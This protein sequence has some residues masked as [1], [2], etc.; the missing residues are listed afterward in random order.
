MGAGLLALTLFA[1]T[2]H[3]GCRNHSVKES[4]PHGEAASQRREAVERAED[5]RRASLGDVAEVRFIAH[6][7]AHADPL[8]SGTAVSRLMQASPESVL[9]VLA[10]DRRGER[11]STPERMLVSWLVSRESREKAAGPTWPVCSWSETTEAPGARSLAAAACAEHRARDDQPVEDLLND[12][13]WIVRCRV[14]TALVDDA[15]TKPGIRAAIARREAHDPHPTVRHAARHAL[16]DTSGT[17][18]AQLDDGSEPQQ[19]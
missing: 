15:K 16:A 6:E 7:L 13:H 1:G 14:V 5:V 9:A 11:W 17:A 3:V 18:D 19:P 12:P 4:K 10:S 2:A 8:V